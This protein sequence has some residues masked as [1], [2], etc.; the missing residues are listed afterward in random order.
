MYDFDALFQLAGSNTSR[1]K[2]Q[3]IISQRICQ[4]QNPCTAS[5]SK[6]RILKS[7]RKRTVF[8]TGLNKLNPDANMKPQRQ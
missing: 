6:I 8:C 1:Q 7:V 4:C 5:I 2:M 3:S